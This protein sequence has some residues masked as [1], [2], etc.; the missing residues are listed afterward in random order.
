MGGS[1]VL[2]KNVE[3][4]KMTFRCKILPDVITYR[5]Q[6]IGKWG[7]K[8]EKKRLLIADSTAEFCV[9]LETILQDEFCIRIAHSGTEALD[10]LDQFAPQMLVLDVTLPGLD[11]IRVLEYAAAQGL[12]MKTL[13]TTP[14]RSEYIFS[15]LMQLEVS[16][17]LMKPCN[18]KIAAERVRDIAADGD[19]LPATA[20]SDEQKLAA[21]LLELG[22]NPKHNG[23]HYLCAAVHLFGTDNTQSLTK[24]LYGAVGAV[25]GVHWQQ[26]ERSV[27]TAL[28]AAWNHRDERIWK[29]WFPAGTLSAAKRPTN[30]EVI[31]RL[32]EHLALAKLRKIG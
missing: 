3:K 10:L 1:F 22:F 25:Y 28:E 17:V 31:C 32:A 26:V 2:S 7:N 14:V 16:Y 8:M 6:N 13:V 5:K 12:R 11:G 9:A 20:R 4:T 21:I 18:L 29:Q 30:G 19:A 24:E 27:R 15:K 23:Y